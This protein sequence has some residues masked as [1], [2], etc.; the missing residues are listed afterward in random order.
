MF[1]P[2]IGVR[3]EITENRIASFE[4]SNSTGCCAL[5]EYEACFFAHTNLLVLELS[6]DGLISPES[7]F[8]TKFTVAIENFVILSL[9]TRYT[10]L[11]WHVKEKRNTQLLRSH[12]HSKILLLMIKQF[13]TVPTIAQALSRFPP[14]AKMTD[15]V[16]GVF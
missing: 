8:Y 11:L 3:K 4:R 9:Q 15:C 7:Y 16:K 14:S 5:S 12:H 10:K 1:I 2:Y 6:A 13:I